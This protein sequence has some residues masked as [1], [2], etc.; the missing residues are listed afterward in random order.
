MNKKVKQIKIDIREVVFSNEEG[1]SF[2]DIFIYEPENIDE[3]SLGSLYILGEV[4]NFPSNS[5]YLI[6]LLASIAKKEFYSDSKKSTTESLEASLHKVNSTLS[7]MAEQGN[8]DWI[9]NLN[10][11]FCA[12]KNEELH[13]SQAGEIKTILIRDK[14]ITDIG[15]NVIS[16]TN[17][18]PIRTF[19]N[20]ASG[21]LEI[22]DLVLFATPEL[23]NVFSTEKLKQLSSSLDTEELAEAVQNA[24]EKEK[25]INTM[26]LF[27]MKVEEEKEEEF[28][29]I[30]IKS[31]VIIEK[32]EIVPIHQEEEEKKEEENIFSIEKP[33][34]EKGLVNE[35]RISLEDII[36]EYEADNE[37]EF[38]NI[39]NPKSVETIIEERE[40]VEFLEKNNFDKKPDSEET[41]KFLQALDEESNVSL[42]DNLSNKLKGIMNKESLVS[43]INL[44]KNFLSSIQKILR[45]DNF[46]QDSS[47]KISFSSERKKIILASF[48][49]ILIILT[50]GL[51]LENKKKL[52]E[53]NYQNYQNLIIKAE[54][55]ISQA[56]IKSINSP[57][58]ARG[59]L[60]EARGIIREK[61][62]SLTGKNYQDLNNKSS[63]LI[64]KIQNQLDILDFVEKIENPRIVIDLNQFENTKNAT[65]IFESGNKYFV[66]GQDNITFSEIN[67]AEKNVKNFD[68]GNIEKIKNLDISS[69]MK[70]TDE[71]IFLKN[72]NKLEILNSSR[73]TITS[74][75]INFVDNAFATKE[76]A[77]Y[78]N[79]LYL[80]SPESNQIYK[81]KRL[82]NGFD[83][84]VKWLTEE[85]DIKNSVSI[86]I[87]GSIYLL[88]SDGL[89]NKFRT[90]NQELFAIE[91]PSNPIPSTA[92]IYTN[93]NLK[94]L[95]VTDSENKRVAL[96]DKTTGILVKQ[97]T[98]EKFNDIKN[99]VIDSE[100]EKIYILNGSEIFE[101]EIKI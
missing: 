60:L 40:Q 93:S 94:Y 62:R 84:G 30:E 6:N 65:K 23:F 85:M 36:K 97:Y 53:E 63:D 91:I 38:E 8:I 86:A 50:G 48:I 16:E 66:L 76:I 41:D 14:Q 39:E 29:H 22:G 88:N 32:E 54:E 78:S 26:G 58:D 1:K 75:S 92:R 90:G 4:V 9:G 25:D 13:L 11:I 52:D 51:L 35:K 10:M 21:E 79:Y 3:Q 15:K 7:D 80:L 83:D 56:E 49:L 99:I 98:S 101:I 18:H 20:I 55:K 73:K 24:I 28:T 81:Y 100:E 47:Q 89:I 44:V 72:E 17:S 33:E 61:D 68:I 37:N 57:S 46:N 95:Y 34:S 19:A 64:N 87:D 5:S 27:I 42:L 2:C 45:K 59:Y 67:I 96:F 71:I 77:S 70:K 31:Q 82:T 74:E 69:F 43:L 12:Y